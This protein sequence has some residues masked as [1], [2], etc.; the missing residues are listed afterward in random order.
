[1]KVTRCAIYELMRIEAE[2]FGD[3]RELFLQGLQR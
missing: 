3:A 2:A 1:M